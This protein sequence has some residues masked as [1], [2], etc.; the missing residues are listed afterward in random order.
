[1]D[2]PPEHLHSLI[3]YKALK[4]D[5]D[6]V[7]ALVANETTFV[8]LIMDST[9]LSLAHDVMRRSCNLR[10]EHSEYLGYQSEGHN[11]W[12]T[13]QQDTLSRLSQALT[14]KHQANEKVA[15]ERAARR[16]KEGSL[17]APNAFPELGAPDTNAKPARLRPPKAKPV[18]VPKPVAPRRG[19]GPPKD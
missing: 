16:L 7:M 6:K 12:L 13:R 10:W 3:A 5:I 15:S 11:Y 18:G 1:M 14:D 2:S 17:S 19:L 9:R 4:P 8:D